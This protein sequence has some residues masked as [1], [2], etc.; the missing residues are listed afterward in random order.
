MMNQRMQELAERAAR[1]HQGS[2]DGFVY[3]V[4]TLIKLIVR[5][6]AGIYEAINN[7]NKVNGTDDYLKALA[8]N[9]GIKKTR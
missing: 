8:A 7:G 2:T 1:E 4:E 9:F 6:C 3:P 5:E